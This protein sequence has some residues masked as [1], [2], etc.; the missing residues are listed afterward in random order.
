[1][2]M[3]T[4]FGNLY[5]AAVAGLM[6]SWLANAA[7]AEDATKAN[8]SPASVVSKKKETVWSLVVKGGIVMIPLSL[9]SVVGLGI[10][11]ERFVSLRRSKIVP[12]NFIGGLIEQLQSS[13]SNSKAAVDYCERSQSPVG[14]IFRAG[15]QNLSRGEAAVER[16]IEDAGGREADKMKR[17]LQGLSV[18]TTVSPLLGLLGTVYGMIKAF[19]VASYAGTGKS[20]LLARGIYEALVATASGLTVAIASLLLYHYFSKRIDA[21]MDEIDQMGLDFMN[22]INFERPSS[23]SSETVIPAAHR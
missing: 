10:A 13:G 19:E 21:L 6:L 4:R 20:E 14:N 1:M 12:P 3:K 17:S 18:I 16:A 11:I 9:C 23:R 7:L 2:K 5:I 15:I 22:H 8:A